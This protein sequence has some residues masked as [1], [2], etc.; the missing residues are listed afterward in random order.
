M[1][2]VAG[3]HR[4][5]RTT[6]VALGVLVAA[7][8]AFALAVHRHYPIQLWL[9]WR[10]ATYWV[11]S[12]LFCFSC[13]SSGCWILRKVCR[14]LLPMTELVPAAI[15]TGLMAY[16]LGSFLVGLCGGFGPVFALAWPGALC[17]LDPRGA[18]RRLARL[19]RVFARSSK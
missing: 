7:T 14:P 13:F 15:A 12:L 1:S 16:F 18:L 4:D 8:L 10:F 9:F 5:R 11:L 17:L 6:L 2:N 19:A 3:P